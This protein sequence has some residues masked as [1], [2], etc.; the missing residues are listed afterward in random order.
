MRE[1]LQSIVVIIDDKANSDH[2]SVSFGPGSKHNFARVSNAVPHRYLLAAIIALASVISIVD[3]CIEAHSVSPSLGSSRQTP[4]F[5]HI[6]LISN[7][8]E[9]TRMI[10]LWKFSKWCG[11]SNVAN[12]AK[13]KHMLQVLEYE[14]MTLRAVK[15][16]PIDVT[17]FTNDL[18]RL[19]I[20]EGKT[21]IDASSIAF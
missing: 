4:C 13:G 16:G 12:T 21:S 9:L 20:E 18:L 1:R 5:D 7:V 17:A 8:P 6:A 10:N 3:K 11:T 15:T 14:I 19:E 2:T